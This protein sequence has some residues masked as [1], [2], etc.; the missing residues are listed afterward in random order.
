MEVLIQRFPH[1][2][3][4]IFQKLDNKSLVRSREVKISWQNLI[5]E[6]NPGSTIVTDE[7]NSVPDTIVGYIGKL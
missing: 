6:R 2:P 5:D 3:E 1:L 4:Q 7:S